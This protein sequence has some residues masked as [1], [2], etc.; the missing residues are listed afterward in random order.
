MGGGQLELHTSLEENVLKEVIEEY[1]CLGEILEQLP[2]L[3][4]F[5][6]MNGVETHWLGIPFVIKVNPD[7]VKLNEPEYCDEL[8]WFTLDN[9][10]Q[11]LHSAYEK[12]FVQYK[13]YF[14]KYR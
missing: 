12:A 4:V 13:E 8:G 1:G 2:P 14:E 9:L 5:R 11:P 7:E 6:E 10:P 3:E